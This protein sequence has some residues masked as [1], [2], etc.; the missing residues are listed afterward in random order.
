MIKLHKYFYP[1]VIIC[2]MTISTFSYAQ[3]AD[4]DDSAFDIKVTLLG[5]GTPNPNPNQMG[6]SILVEAGG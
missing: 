3:T 2:S 1:F 4:K 6:Q 5:T